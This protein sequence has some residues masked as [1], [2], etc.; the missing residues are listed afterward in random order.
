[1]SAVGHNLP[2]GVTFQFVL[3]A[4]SLINLSGRYSVS[5]LMTSL[6]QPGY[7]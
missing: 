4:R 3:V 1:M 5:K 6:P 2:V 7:Q